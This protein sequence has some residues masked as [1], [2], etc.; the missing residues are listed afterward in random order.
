MYKNVFFLE[1]NLVTCHFI[2]IFAAD[3]ASPNFCSTLIVHYCKDRVSQKNIDG[4]RRL[5]VLFVKTV[6]GKGRFLNVTCLCSQIS[7]I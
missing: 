6:E 3:L 1:K 4:I 7:Q 2:C 5:C